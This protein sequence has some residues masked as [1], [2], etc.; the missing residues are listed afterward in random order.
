MLFNF[1]S[2][3]RLDRSVMVCPVSCAPHFFLPPLLNFILF[4]HILIGFH[5]VRSRVLRCLKHN[6]LSSPKINI[7]NSFLMKYYSKRVGLI[8][9]CSKTKIPSDYANPTYLYQYTH[10]CIYL[11]LHIHILI[12]RDR[13]I[14]FIIYSL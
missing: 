11:Y 14:P 10:M 9:S 8:C 13:R 4:L 6:L 7:F 5:F 1:S 12:Y 3:V 2:S